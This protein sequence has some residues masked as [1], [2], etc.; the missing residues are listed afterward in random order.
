MTFV[1][2]LVFGI[3]FMFSEFATG[4]FYLL[5]IGFAFAYPAAAA[6]MGASAGMQMAALGAGAL[7]H[8]LIVMILRKFRA[9]G[10]AADIPEDVGQR[11]EVIEWLD[12]GS[13]RVMHRGIEWDA[14]KARAEMPN[15]AL[16]SSSPYKAAASS[17]RR[18]SFPKSSQA[19][20]EE[21]NW[22][23]LKIF[24]SEFFSR[25]LLIELVTA[26]FSR[27]SRRIWA[28]RIIIKKSPA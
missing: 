3:I 9:G 27:T 5:A 2:W 13:A 26:R 21:N 14:D 11:V 1:S 28:V 17:S 4:T 18:N 10:T 19:L 24:L 16:A 12:E 7:A 8:S 23:R 22:Y 15:A 25:P 20:T 6:Y